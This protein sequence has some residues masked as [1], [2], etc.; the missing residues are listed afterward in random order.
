MTVHNVSINKEGLSLLKNSIGL[1]LYPYI[2]ENEQTKAVYVGYNH[3]VCEA[4][5]ISDVIKAKY[6]G[7]TIEQADELLEM[8]LKLLSII[9]RR[10]LI[11]E[12]SENQ[13]SA[14]LCLM[15]NIGRDKFIKSKIIKLCNVRDF[16]SVQKYML[17]FNKTI[18]KGVRKVSDELT[19]LHRKEVLLFATESIGD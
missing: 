1:R 4:N 5:S 12:L 10:L 19:Q 13:F 3:F 16:V 7:F 15:F 9:L 6:K 8:E 17:G 18:E 2:L 11:V 14:L